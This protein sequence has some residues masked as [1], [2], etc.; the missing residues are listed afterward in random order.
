MNTVVKA[1]VVLLVLVLLCVTAPIW[2]VWIVLDNAGV[3]E[4]HGPAS[5]P[6]APARPILPAR[7]TIAPSRDS[8][9]RRLEY[10]LENYDAFRYFDLPPG[11]V[12]YVP[13]EDLVV[14]P[15]EPVP[16]WALPDDGLPF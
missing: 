14:L 8:A 2:F 15:P 1:A 7:P 10:L 3:F 11:V 4:P 9:R 16:S 12:V 5:R 6:T 13:T